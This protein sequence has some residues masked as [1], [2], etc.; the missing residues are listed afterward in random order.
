MMKGGVLV[1]FMEKRIPKRGGPQDGVG[2]G[3][4]QTQVTEFGLQATEKHCG[5][6]KIHFQSFQ[7]MGEKNVALELGSPGTRFWLC[8]L[9]SEVW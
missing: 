6:L 8:H 3:G 5:L 1:G 2:Q 7:N 4:P 9:Q